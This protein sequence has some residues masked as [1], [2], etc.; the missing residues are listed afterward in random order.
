[1]PY[2][3]LAVAF[4]TQA[5]TECSIHAP[6]AAPA[7]EHRAVRG[8]G[9]A[10]LPNLVTRRVGGPAFRLEGREQRTQGRCQS[11]LAL[12]VDGGKPTQALARQRLFAKVQGHQACQNEDLVHAHRPGPGK[13]RGLALGRKRQRGVRLYEISGTGR[14]EAGLATWVH[15]EEVHV[16]VLIGVGRQFQPVSQALSAR[17]TVGAD[18]SFRRLETGLT[19]MLCALMTRPAEAEVSRPADINEM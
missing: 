16:G 14:E 1:M 17:I 8:A 2:R 5:F 7:L 19:I 13:R 10:H 18:V 3:D 15:V 6:Q 12:H 11:C 4:C 9:K